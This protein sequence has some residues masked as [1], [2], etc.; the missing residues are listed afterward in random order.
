MK[1]SGFRGFKGSSDVFKSYKHPK[2]L[3]SYLF[4]FIH[5]RRASL[6]PHAWAGHPR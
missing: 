6:V 2:T 5:T 4:S 3:E 1:G